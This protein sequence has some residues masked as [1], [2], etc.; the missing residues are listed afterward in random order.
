MEMRIA[1]IAAPM[2]SA[3]QSSMVGGADR[4]LPHGRIGQITSRYVIRHGDSV[5]SAKLVSYVPTALR[6]D[7]KVCDVI[8][9]YVLMLDRV[10]RQAHQFDLLRF[11]IDYLH[12]PLFQACIG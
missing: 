3:P 4:F 7:P 11:D 10:R 2:E 12:F 8:P 6:L 5:T 1:Q 9:C